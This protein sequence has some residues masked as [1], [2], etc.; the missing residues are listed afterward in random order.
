MVAAAIHHLYLGIRII[1][2]DRDWAWLRAL[3]TRLQAISRPQDRFDRLVPPAITVD[4]GIE[5]MDEAG[6]LP[7][8]RKQ[9]DIDYRD[10]LIMALLSL[11][12]LRRRSIAALTVTRH[13]ELGLHKADICLFPEDT[14]SGRA[15]AGLSRSSYFPIC[16][17]TSARS[18]RAS[19]VEPSMMLSGSPCEAARCPA[20]RSIRS[21]A[22]SRRS[23]SVSLWGCMTSGAPRLR[24]WRRTRLTNRL[25]ARNPA[26][27]E[28][29]RE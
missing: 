6:L 1:A 9:R 12:P 19:S 8:A 2:P 25:G 26:A 24:F 15:E 16:S 21:F 18:G 17:V 13:L 23:G 5:M 28:L 4:L 7:I 27:H 10:G 11:W 29:H 14:K 3:R 20:T 22:A